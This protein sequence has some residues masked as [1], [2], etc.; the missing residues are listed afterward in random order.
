MWIEQCE[1][2]FEELKKRLTIAPILTLRP[3]SGGFI[4]YIDAS[5]VGLGCVLMQ[6]GKV[7]SYGLRQLK[8]YERNY[9]THDL[10]LAAVVFELKMWRHYL[11]WEKFE[12][13]SDHRSLQY[14]FSHREIVSRY[15]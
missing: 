7:I 6:D 9:A 8:D 3:G 11:Y 2:S 14:L 5:N 13:H 1:A 12:V 10:E 4:V 15:G